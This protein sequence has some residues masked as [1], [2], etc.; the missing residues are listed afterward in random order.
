MP[1]FA[2][3]IIVPCRNNQRTLPRCLDSLVQQSLFRSGEAEIIAADDGSDDRSHE[4]ALEFQQQY[5]QQFRLHR[6]SHQGIAAA[7]ELGLS[8]ARGAYVAFCDAR[9]WAEP[10]LYQALH[11][12]CEE[13][14]A[15]IAACG[16]AA[17]GLRRKE[18]LGLAQQ[19][20]VLEQDAL[21]AHWADI[22][23]GAPGF[24]CLENK[25]F[26]RAFLLENSLSVPALQR[27]AQL[28]F[29]AQSLA[30]CSRLAAVPRLLYHRS[31]RGNPLPC[32]LDEQLVLFQAL[33]AVWEQSGSGEPVRRRLCTQWVRRWHEACRQERRESKNSKEFYRRMI[34]LAETQQMQ[35]TLAHADR[36]ALPRPL[37]A[38]FDAFAARDWIQ[39]EGRL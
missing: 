11:A 13:H 27:D 10:E 21:R 16:M 34:D 31:A 19:Q 7:L 29:T 1:N 17:Q 28:L 23:T 32:C 3:S 35:A 37:A 14:A 4:I 39:A 25:L 18:I 6:Q 26:R 20:G 15:D 38:F 12:A 5:P 30:A 22:L 9:D 36:A 8:L 2:V 24:A 33:Y